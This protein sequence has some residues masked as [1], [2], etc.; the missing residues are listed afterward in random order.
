MNQSNH[1]P[2]NSKLPPTLLLIGP[3]LAVPG[4]VSAFNTPQRAGMEKSLGWPAVCRSPQGQWPASTRPGGLRE[5]QGAHSGRKKG[6]GPFCMSQ[7]GG[8]GQLLG[9]LTMIF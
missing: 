2:S 3:G 6:M 7:R 9:V 4:A 5:L 1:Q 8:M